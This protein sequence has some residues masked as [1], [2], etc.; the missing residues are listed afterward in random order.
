MVAF[1]D[2][3]A[4]HWQ[5]VRTSDP[6]E[7]TFGTLRHRPSRSKG[8]LTRDGMLHMMFKL[9]MCAKGKWSKLR[10][11]NDLAK[12]ITGIKFTDGIEVTSDHLIR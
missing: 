9:G 6:I 2:Y 1:Y 5:S 3:P 12:V 8:C 10:G 7:S 11:F 4:Q